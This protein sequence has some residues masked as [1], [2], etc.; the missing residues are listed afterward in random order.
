ML[1]GGCSGYGACP[2]NE[3]LPETQA[4][5]RKE[6]TLAEEEAR[7]TAEGL[8][9]E[10]LTDLVIGDPGKGQAESSARLRLQFQ[11]QPET[12][13]LSKDCG[14]ASLSWRTGLQACALKR[15]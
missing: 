13:S 14:V 7:K 8:S 9:D 12:G 10:Q 15:I 4:A 11:G 2:E 3:K 1:P 6:T 5:P